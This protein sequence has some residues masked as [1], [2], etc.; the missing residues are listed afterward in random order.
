M[1]IQG[2]IKSVSVHGDNLLV[3]AVGAEVG[4]DTNFFGTHAVDFVVRDIDRNRRTLRVGRPL[5]ITVEVK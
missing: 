5:T 1:K 4:A 2:E 3:R